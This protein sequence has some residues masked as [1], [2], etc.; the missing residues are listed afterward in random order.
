MTGG[1]IS[2]VRALMLIL[3]F[4]GIYF[5]STNYSD[6]TLVGFIVSMIICTVYWIGGEIEWGKSENNPRNKNV[7]R[8]T[9]IVEEKVTNSTPSHSI[10]IIAAI[11]TIIGTIFLFLKE[12]Q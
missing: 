4:F 7:E 8:K 10:I 6:L 5:L 12:C 11:C 9:V 1:R 3:I 2:G